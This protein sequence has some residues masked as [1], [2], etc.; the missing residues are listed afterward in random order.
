[1]FG[2]HII[3]LF[4]SKKEIK[5]FLNQVVKLAFDKF[6]SISPKTACHIWLLFIKIDVYLLKQ[7]I[8]AN[9]QKEQRKI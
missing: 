2:T 9:S 4:S 1:V 6:N 7:G 8:V 5:V 3:A